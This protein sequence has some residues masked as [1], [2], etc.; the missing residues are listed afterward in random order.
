MEYEIGHR[1]AAPVY[2]VS[3]F[4]GNWQKETLLGIES[5]WWGAMGWMEVGWRVSD[6]LRA[7]TFKD[8]CR[9]KWEWIAQQFIATRANS[10]W[11]KQTAGCV[12]VTQLCLTL[13]GPMDWEPGGHQVPPSMKVSKQEYWSGLSFPSP[14]DLP[15]PGIEPRSP[16]LQA[17][18][19]HLSHHGSLIHWNWRK[20]YSSHQ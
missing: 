20:K 15:D 14:G 13:R 1:Q 17:D 11:K 8:D 7:R 19:Y 9:S 2:S 5:L 18:F 6:L 10:L 12:L 3:S 16:A 4:P